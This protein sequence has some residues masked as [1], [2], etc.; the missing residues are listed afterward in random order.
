L[1]KIT[2]VIIVERDVT[3]RSVRLSPQEKITV[4]S[5]N[6]NRCIL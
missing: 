4:I 5:S 2:Q 1:N 6:G 3:E